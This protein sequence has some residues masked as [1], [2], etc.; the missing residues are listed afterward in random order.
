LFIAGP[1]LSVTSLATG[2]TR[3]LLPAETLEGPLFRAWTPDSRNLIAY[4]RLKGEQAL[5][6][7][8]IDG[9]TPSKINVT[10][11]TGITSW[12]FHPKTGQVMYRTGGGRWQLE[13]WKL[14]NYQSATR[15]ASSR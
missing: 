8:P 1:R 10:S 13:V 15:S 14:E 7:I 4:G 2:Q 12:A 11:P 6:M 3:D 9:S 5:W